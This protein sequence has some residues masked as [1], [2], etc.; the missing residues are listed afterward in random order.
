MTL[1]QVRGVDIGKKF[2][3][4][5]AG[6]QVPTLAEVIALARDRIKL[7]I[8]L[9]YYDQGSEAGQGPEPCRGRGPD[10]RARA[11]R[12]PVHRLLAEL[13]STQ[14]SPPVQSPNPHGCDCHAGDRRY[15]PARRRCPE[16]QRRNR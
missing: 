8:E 1:D 9:K 14:G 12:V 7:Q 6:E 3:S 2:S 16:R 10:G 15:R 11:L 4:A 5:F 13:R